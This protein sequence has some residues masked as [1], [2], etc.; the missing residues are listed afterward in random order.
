[1]H[2]PAPLKIGKHGSIVTDAPDR[3]VMIADSETVE[4]YGGHVVCETITNENAAHMVYSWNNIEAAER[5]RDELAAANAT[6]EEEVKRLRNDLDFERMSHNRTAN[7]LGHEIT[8][9]ESAE[10]G[11]A[12]MNQKYSEAMTRLAKYEKVTA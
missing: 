8:R 5:E 12:L 7:T 2:T 6:L 11:L 1:M 3:Q 9:R 10:Q 4:W